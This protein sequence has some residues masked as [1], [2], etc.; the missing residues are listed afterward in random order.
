MKLKIH[1][2]QLVM[3]L[4]LFASYFIYTGNIV[5]EYKAGKNLVNWNNTE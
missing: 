2:T 4:L 1:F 3:L 5:C